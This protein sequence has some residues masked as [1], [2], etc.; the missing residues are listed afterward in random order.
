MKY[1]IFTIISF[2]LF[3]IP[4]TAQG[5]RNISYIE[6]NY[7]EL[8]HANLRKN[9]LDITISYLKKKN[10]SSL[11]KVLVMTLTHREKGNFISIDLCDKDDVRYDNKIFGYT[12]ILDYTFILRGNTKIGVIKKHYNYQKQF[13]FDN[14]APTTDG[15]VSWSFYLYGKYVKLLSFNEDW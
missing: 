3:L 1:F 2:L 10:I 11:K 8:Y 13:T 14:K 15:V 4:C 12:K 9:I 6:L 7:Y 5:I